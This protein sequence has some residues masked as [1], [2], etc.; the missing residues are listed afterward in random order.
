MRSKAHKLFVEN[1]QDIERLLKLHE[2]LGGKSQGRRRGLEVLN[3]SAIVLITSIWEAYCEDIASEGLE[4]I[5]KHGRSPDT[6]PKEIKKIIA[7]GMG[8]LFNSFRK[9]LTRSRYCPS[10]GDLCGCTREKHLDAIQ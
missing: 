5:V 8:T 4:H 7:M 3:K 2:E 1:A 6:L 9:P 10:G